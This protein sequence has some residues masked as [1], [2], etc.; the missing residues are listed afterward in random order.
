MLGTLYSSFS[1]EAHDVAE[2]FNVFMAK[3][4][5]NVLIVQWDFTAASL[6][7]PRHHG[8]IGPNAH[9]SHHRLPHA[10]GSTLSLNNGVNGADMQNQDKGGR[11]HPAPPR[12]EVALL[13]PVLVRFNPLFPLSRLN[14]IL[15][16]IPVLITLRP[17]S[18][19]VTSSLQCIC[20]LTPSLLSPA[21]PRSSS[22]KDRQK[23]ARKI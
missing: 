18:S 15:Q 16:D 23:S 3:T 10:M 9:G 12:N 14:S 17:G 4:S 20:R 5:E 13:Q 1:S 19:R 6:H 22:G 7:R 21:R 8:H 2:P 11:Y